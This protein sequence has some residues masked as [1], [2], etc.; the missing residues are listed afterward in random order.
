MTKTFN[1]VWL[2]GLAR[3]SFPYEK[4]KK[5]LQSWVLLVQDPKLLGPAAMTQLQSWVLLGQNPTLMV[6]VGPN[7]IRF[8]LLQ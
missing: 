7:A 8:W 2:L 1:W 3:Q 4:E 5:S 6:L